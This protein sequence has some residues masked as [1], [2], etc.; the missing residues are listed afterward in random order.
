MSRVQSITPEKTVMAAETSAP[1]IDPGELRKALGTFMT[2]VTVVTTVDEAGNPRGFTANSFTSVS[3][4]PPLI[5]VCIAHEALSYPVYA[6]TERFAVNILEDAQREVSGVFAGKAP[7]KFDHVSWRHERTG[8]PIIDGSVAWLDCRV[9]DRV[10]AGDH[11]VLIG[12]VVDFDHTAGNPL[13]YC[14][15]SYL[16]SGLEQDA[17]PSPGQATCIGA[18]LESDGRVLLIENEPGGSL[19]LPAGSKFGRAS[20]S[21]SLQAHLQRLQIDAE[22]GFLFAV[23]EED[24]SGK[25]Y[26]YYR[27]QIRSAPG[28]GAGVKLFPLSEIPFERMENRAVGSMLERYVRERLDD[29]FGVYVGDFEQGHVERLSPR[30]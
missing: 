13:G 24:A 30:R 20:D 9:H 25:L 16:S 17:I 2:G 21:T 11:M 27:G 18:I 4:D 19:R 8:S 1:D 29:Q 15:G 22:I 7:D 26:V 6:A 28:D 12:R 5:L 10:D 14:R 23:F 3:L